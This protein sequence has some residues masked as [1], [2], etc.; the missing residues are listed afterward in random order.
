MTKHDLLS[1]LA[2]E[3]ELDALAVADRL[4]SSVEAA[5]MVLLRL[6]RQGLI[7]RELDPDNHLYFYSLTQ[8]GHARFDFFQRRS[9]CPKENDSASKNTNT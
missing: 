2:Q 7:Q 5:G 3:P 9:R 6:F 1:L 4:S 8:K